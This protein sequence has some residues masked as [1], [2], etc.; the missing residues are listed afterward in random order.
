MERQDMAAN[1][2]RFYIEVDIDCY[3][4]CYLEQAEEV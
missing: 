4:Y 1:D 3:D 2:Y